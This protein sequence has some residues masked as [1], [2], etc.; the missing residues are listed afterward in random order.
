MPIPK[1]TLYQKLGKG[2]EGGL[3]FARIMD[4]LIFANDKEKGRE[5]IAT[6]DA[7]GDYKGVDFI[8]KVRVPYGGRIQ[9]KGYQYKFYPSG[10]KSNQKQEIEKSIKKAIEKFP[11]MSSWVLVTPENLNK[12]DRQWFQ[13]IVNEYSSN[14]EIKISAKWS[15]SL[16]GDKKRIDIRHMGHTEI[17]DLMLKH[18]Q[19]GEQYYEELFSN[20]KGKLTLVK[21]AVDTD[22]TNWYRSSHYKNTFEIR[23][24]YDDIKKSNELV[25][26]FQFI[27]NTA[28][29]Y[30][31]QRIDVIL[32][33]IWTEI[34]GPSLDDILLPGRTI[35]FELDFTK[36]INSISLN[37][38][39]GGPIIFS[40]MES[41]RFD[42]HLVDFAKKCPG[43]NVQLRFEFVFDSVTL[44]SEL[45]ALDF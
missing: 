35:P 26:D 5:G 27:N 16:P 45:Y 28:L 39:L 1:V 24:F 8:T 17:M 32:E 42:L 4:Q 18:Q 25:F 14:N 31:L 41:K 2:A 21:A 13:G 37:S 15:I 9:Y 29:V 34:K 3:H 10:L 36:K 38:I 6:S 7:A 22:R 44:K 43:N 23:T 11:E 12:F 19:I 30:H 33:K 40:P 20:K